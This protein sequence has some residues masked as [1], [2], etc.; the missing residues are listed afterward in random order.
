MNNFNAVLT[1]IKKNCFVPGTPR[2]GY[3]S[4]I[5]RELDSGYHEHID[6][7]LGFLNDLGLIEYD[8]QLQLITLTETG[9]ST[10]AL[11]A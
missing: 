5:K 11:F 6:F 7:Y 9:K 4:H 1:I 3:M 2:I 8:T 10:T